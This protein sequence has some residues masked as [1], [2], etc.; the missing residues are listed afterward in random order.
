MIQPA[1]MIDWLTLHLDASLLSSDV[2]QFVLDNTDRIQKITPSTGEIH[3]ESIARESLRSDSHQVTVSF[4]SRLTIQG[5]PARVVS[6]NNVFGS[7]DIK[8]CALDMI[9]FV[10]THWSVLLPRDLSI[11]A[12]TR[13]DI[14]QNH[15]MGSLDQ[16]LSV[17]DQLKY[18]KIGRQRSSTEETTAMWG[19]GSSLHNGKAYA[20]GPHCRMLHAR[21]NAVFTESELQKADRLLRLEY[22][23]RRALI[24]RIYQQTGRRWHEFD[25]E[26]LIAYHNSYFS[27]FISDLA[28]TDMDNVL[29]LVLANVGKGENQIPSEGR[30]RAAYDCYCRCRTLG[31][32]QA[33]E[34][35]PK[36]TWHKHLK[37]LSTVGIR[38]VDLQP[39]NVVPLRRR[40]VVLDKPVS[41]WD[42][43]QLVEKR[44]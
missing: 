31:F 12:C 38:A 28:V 3:W 5:S 29:D 23:M 11:W 44:A 39:I 40:S 9:R 18:V 32:H 21:K 16:V 43:I 34:S 41:C 10:S 24:T 36:S 14:N 4:G 19:K 6:L 33:K 17:I 20:K 1:G 37:Y 22:S 15:D 25:A 7:L 8:Q 26:F 27:K 42:D 30:A 2:R 13:I 35:Y